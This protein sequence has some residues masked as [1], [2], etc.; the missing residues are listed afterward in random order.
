MQEFYLQTLRDLLETGLISTSYRV[1]V[2]CGGTMDQQALAIT[3]FR[4]VV[5]S[6]LDTRLKGD[7]FAPFKWSYQDA[8][9]LE[10][11]DNHF[12]LV[13]AHSGL[14][15]CRS[16]HRALLEMYRVASKGV[17]VFEPR[18]GVLVRC[19][20]RLGLGQEY[21]VAAVV[22]NDG[23]YG[24]VENSAVPNYVYRWT[25]RDVEK[26][27]QSYAPHARHTFR[28]FYAL[29]APG[30]ATG[31]RRGSWR[32]PLTRALNFGLA[33]LARFFPAFAN[34]MAFFVGKPALPDDLQPWLRESD[35]SLRLDGK[36]A[37]EHFG[38]AQ[39]R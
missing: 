24:G 4:D 8:E 33:R 38:G 37:A 20:V 21:E 39:V 28:Y 14:H 26:T 34:N 3:G 25:P 23:A 31:M 29:R 11:P 6:N 16:P 10:F 27:I 36:Y 32:L 17:L 18:D 9:R 13:V 5:I 1:L 30:S 12:E 19:G 35:G 7:E 22:A 15:H 2:T